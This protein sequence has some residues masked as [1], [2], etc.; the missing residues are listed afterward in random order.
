VRGYRS[1]TGVGGGFRGA[2]GSEGDVLGVKGNS[3]RKKKRGE[4]GAG[5]DVVLALEEVWAHGGAKNIDTRSEK[6]G[7]LGGG[8]G[9]IHPPKENR[10]EKPG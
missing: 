4:E 1:G 3:S 9:G 5:Q 10:K 6:N 2:R 8:K 7:N